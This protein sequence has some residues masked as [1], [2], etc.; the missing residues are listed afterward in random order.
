M[1][2][3]E[4]TTKELTGKEKRLANLK[5]LVEH[6]GMTEEELAYIH[7]CRVK[8]GKARGEQMKK[9]KNLKE[10]AN[11][12]LETRVSKERAKNILGDI[13][14]DIPEEDLTNGALLIARMLNE[15]YE[16]GTSR[17]AE[18]IR[19][20]SG[21]RPKDIVEANLNVVS[22][23]DRALMANLSARLCKMTEEKAEK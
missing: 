16:N 13:A 21:Q 15:A 8:G 20:T 18:F 4:S 10:L 11:M 22:E 6:D 17:S 9:A 2:E 23:A 5:P 19:D 12:L 3:N 7:E 14:D 1:T